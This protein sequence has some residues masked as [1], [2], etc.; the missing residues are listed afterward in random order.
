M[1]RGIDDDASVRARSSQNETGL[2][3]R[4]GVHC[5]AQDGDNEDPNRV[6]ESRNSP[7]TVRNATA[8]ESDSRMIP[9]D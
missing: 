4:S 5:V 6:A 8:P 1:S 9:P 3:N 2:P 7:P